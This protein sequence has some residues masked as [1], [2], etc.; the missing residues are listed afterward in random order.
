MAFDTYSGYI[1]SNQFEPSTAKSFAVIADQEQFGKFLA[2]AMHL[3]AK[4]ILDAKSQSIPDDVFKSRMVLA[5]IKDPDMAWR[6]YVEKV[7]VEKGVVRLQYASKARENVTVTFAFARPLIVSIPKGNY[8]AVQF[9]ENQRLIT[10]VELRETEGNRGG[11]MKAG[12]ILP[13]IRPKSAG[14]VHRP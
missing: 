8:K 5:V 12:F 7:T 9:V 14:S 1:I 10:T 11:T 13:P 6:Y 4:S 2:V 3:D